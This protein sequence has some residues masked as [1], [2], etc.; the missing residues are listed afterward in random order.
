MFLPLV[1]QM[2][3]YLGGREMLSAYTIGQALAAPPDNDGS[4]P[5]IDSP[6]GRRIEDA[7]KNTTGELVV[8]A[9]EMG[10]YKFRYRDRTEQTAVNL[11]TR[12]SDFAK[13]DLNEFVASITPGEGDQNARP[14]SSPQST[15]E[16][17]ESKQRLWL[18]LLIAALLLF[19][20]EALLARRI[21]IA[22]LVR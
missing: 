21:R 11:D 1:R 15:A 13:L 18:P 17:I 20:T 19:V 9:A 3:E 7:R 16:E 22:K 8:D 2:L 6:S 12:E 10:F 5:A 4:L 14:I